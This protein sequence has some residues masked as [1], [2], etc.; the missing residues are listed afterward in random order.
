[1]TLKRILLSTIILTLSTAYAWSIPY[2]DIRKFSILDGLAANTISD[3]RQ[4]P[5]NLMWFGTW[6]GISFYDGYSF[7]TF[8]DEPD[9]VERLTTNRILY[10][11]PNTRSD[12]WCI[13][14]DN[15]PFVY[16]T[17]MCQFVDVGKKLNEE[18]GI[19]PHVKEIYCLKSGVTWMVTTDGEYVVRFN[20]ET[21]YHPNHELIRTGEKGLKSGKVW[22]IW[23][24]SK[25]REWILTEK[26]T[27]VYGTKFSTNVA[28]KWV[29]SVGKETYLATVDGKLAIV[30]EH[31]R[32]TNIPLPEGVTRINEL[33]NTGYQLLI[34]TNIGVVIYNPRTFSSQVISVQN[35]NQPDP[36]VRKIYVDVSEGLLWAF[37]NGSGVTAINPD[38]YEK[39]WLFA[40]TQDPID[41]T[42]SDKYFIMEDEHK[43]LWVI[44]NHGTFS[45]YDRK[46]RVLVPYILRSNSSGNFRIPKISK[47]AISDQGILW[48]TGVHELTQINFK[49]HLYDT[50]RLDLGESEVRAL[51]LDSQHR[52]WTGFYNGI[53]KISDNDH[54]KIGYLSPSGTIVPQQVQFSQS[55]VYTIFEDGQKRIWIGTKGDGLYIWQNGS[56]QH[57][58]Y[59]PKDINTLPNNNINDIVADRKGHI[60]VATYDGG[61][62]LANEKD[63]N[64]TFISRRNGLPYPNE[65]GKFLKARRLTCTTQGE[66][67]LGTT[68]GLLTFSDNFSS[69]KQ[70]KFYKSEHIPGDTTSLEAN[71]VN[72]VLVRSNGETYISTLGGTL[73]KVKEG[74][75]LQDNIKLSYVK[76]VDESQGVVQSMVEDNQGFV[77]I[78]REASI[79]KFDPQ[80]G[81]FD[82][83]GPNDFD[84]NITFTESRP[85]HDPATNILTVGTP[86]GNVSFDPQVIKKTEYSPKILFT[87]LHFN[88][89]TGFIP[90]LHREK[91]IIPSDKRNLT[92]SFAA[93]DYTRRYQTRYMYRIEGSTPKDEW[94]SLGSR[95]SLSFNHIRHGKWV[96]K[97]KATNTHGFWSNNIGEVTLE[98]EPTFWESIWG[99]LLLFVLIVGAIGGFFYYYTLR[100]KETMAHDLSA[101]KV[102]FF[103]D[104][105]HRL[106]TPLS[107]IGGPVTSVLD[108]EENLSEESRSLLRMV[109]RNTRK[110]LDLI[111]QMLKMDNSANYYVDDGGV[112]KVFAS[113][114]EA[115]DFVDD[116]NASNYIQEKVE[117]S[118]GEFEKGD[119]DITLLCVEDNADLRQFLYSI[120]KTDYNVLL[121][122]NGEIGLEMARKHLPDFILT[123]VTMP[124]MD[125]ITMVQHIKQDRNIAHI[126]IVILSAKASMEDHL[127]AFK[128]GVDG[129]LTKPFS[130]TYLKGRI[131]TII[132]K[133]HIMQQEMLQHID[134]SGTHASETPKPVEPISA[135]A[136][137]TSQQEQTPSET[138]Q[139]VKMTA[140]ENIQEHVKFTAE[141]REEIEKQEKEK[142]VTIDK[143]VKFIV[144][145]I[146]DPDLK[147]DDIAQA[148]AMSRS[149][150]YGKIKSAVGITPVDFVRHIRIMR[151]CEMLKETNDT[152][153]SIAYAVGFSDPKYFSK[154][155]KKEM[156]IIP[157]EYRDNA[158][159]E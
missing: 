134:I 49:D 66:I 86:M 48:M 13:T 107:L 138:V 101:M 37:T 29:R 122:E 65:K 17:H 20:N 104:A 147:I 90:V 32:L 71:D 117:E 59:D 135:A 132:N 50:D 80:S 8:R 43:T 145:R 76:D 9:A 52:Y 31:L 34:A 154:V 144:G 114:G 123:D 110:M 40:D 56:L 83:F 23:C 102:N 126:P 92:I 140:E 78:V 124:V 127:T 159:K 58:T 27:F 22:H 128:E 158:K 70:I 4:A 57:Y 11:R 119:K 10:V 77:W 149:V 69:P 68:D 89:E 42:E 44:P 153:A 25:G 155:F 41:R 98:V 5:D 129:Y 1:M 19:E 75:I 33:K 133:R 55:G 103:S 106:R 30:D 88:G 93:L 38:T 151:A 150:L 85:I 47:Y 142:D 148:M 105:S 72:S 100:Q 39:N 139:P 21:F 51:G 61:L 157:S 95:N 115:G 143:I 53:V 81:T 60:W 73:Q 46:K 45:Y 6:N 64:L 84:L 7:H 113:N 112:D 96:I 131:E 99:K 67:F 63:G 121:A 91:V 108:N 130:A 146:D 14:I 136:Q 109:Q 28:Y 36:E 54:K 26:G 3:M 16:D 15:K 141:E 137:E 87:S 97:V 94:I 2:C 35:P 116:E 74:N 12:I 82:T 156:G 118:A 24:D 111:N 152:L 125:G 120:L 18:Y 79:N 62:A